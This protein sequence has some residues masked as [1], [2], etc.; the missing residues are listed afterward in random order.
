[1]IAAVRPDDWNL[2]LL[3]HIAGAAV[4][5]GSAIIVA[6]TLATA[7]RSSDRAAVAS[8][9]RFG[10]RTML[11]ASLPA[12]VVMRVFAQVVFGQEKINDLPEEPSWILVGF[13]ASELGLLL[14]IVTAVMTAIAGRRL[15]ANPEAGTGLL[16]AGAG[17]TA[18]VLLVYVVTI[19]AMTAK[20]GA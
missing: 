8:L 4:L 18:L 16:R 6:W 2:P 3:L 1:M 10:L 12:Y 11:F 7:A 19:W 14:L 5:V 13:I 9:T 20:P 17:L 15:R